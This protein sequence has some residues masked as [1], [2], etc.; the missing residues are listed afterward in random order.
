MSFS[1]FLFPDINSAVYLVSS[2][3]LKLR[4]VIAGRGIET[5]AGDWPL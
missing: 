5:G 1:I 2:K 4:Y 3:I